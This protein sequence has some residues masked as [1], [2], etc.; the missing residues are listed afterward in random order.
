M[1]I[2]NQKQEIEIMRLVGAT[3]SQVTLPFL[4]Q[5]TL[6]GLISS[7]VSFLLFL[8]GLFFLYEFVK[9]LV[10]S[11]IPVNDVTSAILSSMLIDKSVSF[12]EMLWAFGAVLASHFILGPL[13]GAVSAFLGVKKYLK[14]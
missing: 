12:S 3:D 2:Y 1:T 9:S 8:L 14:I 10:P 13:L 11:T 6:Y 4:W 5:G 7:F